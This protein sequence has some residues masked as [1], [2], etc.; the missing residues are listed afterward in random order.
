MAM[1]YVLLNTELGQE[2]GIIPALENV[3]EVKEIYSVYGV[4]D[5]LIKIE[6]EN[7]DELRNVVTNKIRNIPHI[8]SSLT[9]ITV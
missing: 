5:I 4:Y 1:A 2:S 9:L 6:I 8:R 7:M 3:E